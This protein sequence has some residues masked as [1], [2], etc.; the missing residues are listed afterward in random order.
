MINLNYKFLLRKKV[1]IMSTKDFFMKFYTAETEK[2]VSELIQKLNMDNEEEWIPYGKNESNFSVI[3]NQSSNAERA[4]IEKFTNCVDAVLM[5]KCYEKNLDPEGSECPKSPREALEIFFDLKNG[6]TSEIT[7]NIERELGE[8]ILLMATSKEC[9]PTEKKSKSNPNM[10]IFDKG[11]GQTPNRLQDTILSLLKGNKKSI[12]FTQ[13]NYNQ[14][15]S[16]ALMYCGEKGYCLVISKRNVEIPNEFIDIDDN[17][18]KKWGWTLIRKEIRKDAKDPIYTYY[19]PNGQVP[20]IDEEEL[21]LLPKELNNDESKKYLEYD[22]SCRGFIPYNKKVKCGTAIK[23]YNYKLAKKGPINGHLKYDLASYINDTYLPIR[24]VDCRKNKSSNSVYFRG[25]KKIIEENS[26]E[27]DN[28]KNALVHNRIDVD[29]KINDQEV[30]THIYC[31][32]KRPSSSL[33]A[34]KL[35]EGSRAIKFCLGQQFQGGLTGRFLNSAGLGAIQD[36]III[37]VEFPNISTEFRSNLFMTDRERLYDKAPKKAIEKKL[38][39]IIEKSEELREFRKYIIKSSE[40]ENGKD[41]KAIKEIM[42]EWVEKDPTISELLLGNN[43][44]FNNNSKYTSKDE[45]GK[46]EIDE[47]EES[48]SKDH[49]PYKGHKGNGSETLDKKYYPTYFQPILKVDEAKIY[50]KKSYINEPFRIRFKTDAEDDFFT[51]LKNKGNIKVYINSKEITDF[52][53]IFKNGKV[54]L[55]FSEKISGKKIETKDINISLEYNGEEHFHELIQLELIEKDKSTKE[56][57]KVNRTIGLPQYETRT[58]DNYIS[59]MD[60]QSGVVY[61]NDFGK[62]TYYINIDNIS[63]K[64]KLDSLTDEA[65]KELY[66]QMYTY[67]MLLMAI[68]INHK[69]NNKKAIEGENIDICREIAVVTKEYA[70][71]MFIAEKL[72][73]DLKRKLGK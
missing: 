11:E 71:F 10:I 18:G 54:T 1:L 20:T 26:G 55:I 23:L 19:A 39:D 35:I 43:N 50:H 27:E 65:D 4:L 46:I 8:N 13:G 69:Q 40:D 36:L 2:E 56:N 17:I 72:M 25:F 67:I 42:E 6:D 57:K 34:S 30:V 58:K 37:I 44:I 47:P 68:S 53:R 60:E 64:E 48:E 28:E 62:Y 14:G 52:C 5:K 3:G 31:C 29:F 63:L 32:N 9:M 45:K 15:G 7:K 73:D 66:T 51:R 70:K 24:F 41:I 22:G 21:E 61:V 33:T 49:K 38:K 59:G 12:P 16:G